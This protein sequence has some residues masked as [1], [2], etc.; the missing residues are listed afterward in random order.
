MDQWWPNSKT[1]MKRKKIFEHASNLKDK[2]NKKGRIYFLL[3]QHPKE[4]AEE[5]REILM[6]NRQAPPQ[7]KLVMRVAKN[8]L[9]VNNQMYKKFITPLQAADILR[10]HVNEIEVA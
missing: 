9:M 2:H 1:L 3:D 7:T 10:L 5:R 4:L 8:K 6:E